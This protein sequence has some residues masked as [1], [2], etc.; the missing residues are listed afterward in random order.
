MY[1]YIYIY[2]SKP[3]KAIVVIIGKAHC[4]LDSLGSYILQP[5]YFCQI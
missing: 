1:I 2:I 3:C 5:S 4:S